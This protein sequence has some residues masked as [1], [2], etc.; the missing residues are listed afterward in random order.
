MHL[1][2]KPY[3][4]YTYLVKWKHFCF[5][6]K[7]PWK[8]THINTLDGKQAPI[9]T[10]HFPIRTDN[11]QL[12]PG[13]VFLTPVLPA[14]PLLHLQTWY[15]CSLRMNHC[16]SFTFAVLFQSPCVLPPPHLHPILLTA[17]NYGLLLPCI[18]PFNSSLMDHVEVQT[19]GTVGPLSSEIS[20]L[21]Q[22]SFF[23][24]ACSHPLYK[25]SPI[26][27]KHPDPV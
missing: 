3:W 4:N 18:R 2:R 7:V 13:L 9:L 15:P 1:C 14:P 6:L 24:N 26:P 10:S 23:F 12:V 8:T 16:S 19:T 27:L 5:L 20:L 11:V 22:A 25:A 17:E 21:F